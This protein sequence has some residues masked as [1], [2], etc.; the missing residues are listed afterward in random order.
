MM[1]NAPIV[2]KTILAGNELSPAK[3][4]PVFSCGAIA[5]LHSFEWQI[6]GL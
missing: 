1:G 6:N 3:I 4:S 2:N 5:A